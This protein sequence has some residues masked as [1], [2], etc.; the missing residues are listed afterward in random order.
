[1]SL[2]AKPS[3]RRVFLFLQGPSSSLFYKIA[4]VLEK[5]GHLCLR[6]NLNVGDWLF[7]RRGGAQNYRR[8]LDEWQS[9]IDQLMSSHK[10]TDI[11]LLGEE[12]PYHRVAVDVAKARNIAVTVIEMGYLRPDWITVERDGMSSNSRFPNDPDHIRSA[13]ASLPMPSME[14]IYHQQFFVEAV[15]DIAYNIPNVLLAPLFPG[16]RRHAI[17]HPVL[18]YVGWV[19]RLSQSGRRRKAADAVIEMV[20]RSDQ[21]FFVYPLQLETDYQL[22]AH[23]PYRSQSEAIDEVLTSFAQHSSSDT[24]LIIKIHPLDNGLIDW[25]RQIGGLAESL[26]IT[27]RVHLID[28]GDLSLLALKCR[29]MVTVNSTAVLNSLE[30]GLP[31]KVLGCAI[32]D[33]RGMTHQGNLDTF[34]SAPEKPEPDLTDCFFRLM[35]NTIH[36]RGNFYSR[37]GTDSAAADIGQKLLC[38]EVSG[39]GADCGYVPRVKPLKR[40]GIAVERHA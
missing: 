1:M 10:V 14:K 23:S 9:Y 4:G 17:F 27:A 22:R 19:R 5:A 38:H 31:V 11:V 16:Y 35:A 12:R 37:R 28:G 24:A 32:Y 39:L 40:T 20:M 13:G 29:G 6:V 2:V 30:A 18:E 8:G 36:V 3:S 34:W 25:A 15:L 21:P 33:V 7:W 26:G